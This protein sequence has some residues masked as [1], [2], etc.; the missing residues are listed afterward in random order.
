MKQ[1]VDIATVYETTV[2]EATVEE[3]TVDEA[4]VNETIVMVD[5][6]TDDIKQFIKQLFNEATGQ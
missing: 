5:K 3:T 1:L 4:T 6:T 2:N